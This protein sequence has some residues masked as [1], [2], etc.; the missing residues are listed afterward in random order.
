MRFLLS[1]AFLLAFV[2]VLCVQQAE[3]GLRSAYRA[4]IR[5]ARHSVNAVHT[6]SAVVKSRTYSGTR[7]R[8]CPGGRCP[9]N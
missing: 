9:A 6:R 7:H 4:N 5:H 3:A 8:V 1:I 2:V